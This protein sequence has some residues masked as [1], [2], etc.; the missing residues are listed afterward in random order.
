LSANRC[1]L[2]VSLL[3]HLLLVGRVMLGAPT[4]PPQAQAAWPVL[5]TSV[6]L[7]APAATL[8]MPAAPP[9][10]SVHRSAPRPASAHPAPAAPQVESPVLAAAPTALPPNQSPTQSPNPQPNPAPGAE[11][12]PLAAPGLLV[13]AAP[14][15]PSGVVRSVAVLADQVARPPER[16]CTEQQLARHYP[17]L[18]RE[19]GIEGQVML[20]VKVDEQGHA[21]EVQVQGGSGW[22]LLDEAAQ[23]LALGCPYVPARRGGQTL[24][25]WVEYPVRFALNAP[26]QRGE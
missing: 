13:G 12:R 6:W 11:P 4:R 23:R 17:S 21:A 3:L 9:P 20:R 26:G 14:S 24:S 8:A 7:P 5:V 18:L 19:R 10:Q 22:R 16:A 2:A 25:S 1:A 15:A